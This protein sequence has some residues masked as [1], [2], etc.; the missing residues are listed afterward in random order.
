[1]QSLLNRLSRLMAAIACVCLVFLMVVTFLDVT[2][3]YL[4]DAPLTFAVE[5]IELSMGLLVSLGLAIT[6][7]NRGHIAVDLLSNAVGST[8][9]QLLARLSAI[10]G[11]IVFGLMAWRLWDRAA[12]FKDDGLATQV[13]FL[14]VYPVVMVMSVAALVAALVAAWLVFAPNSVNAVSADSTSS[15]D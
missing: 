5:L 10:V 13:L 2:G 4:F 1:M 15:Y 8:G 6:T 12:N 14:P 3:R 11:A 7:L 9:R